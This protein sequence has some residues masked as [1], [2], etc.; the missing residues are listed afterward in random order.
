MGTNV[1]KENMYVMYRLSTGSSLKCLFY[2]SSAFKKPEGNGVKTL[3][4]KNI[5]LKLSGKRTGLK[6]NEQAANIQRRSIRKPGGTRPLQKL[7]ESL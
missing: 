4:N 2:D 3:T 7:Q 1:L 6:I 5:F